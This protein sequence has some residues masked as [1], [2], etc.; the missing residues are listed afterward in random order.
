MGVGRD[1]ADERLRPGKCLGGIGGDPGQPRRAGLSRAVELD[2]Q[3]SP[4]RLDRLR[5]GRMLPE[6]HLPPRQR[7]IRRH[8]EGGVPAAEDCYPSRSHCSDPQISMHELSPSHRHDLR[9]PAPPPLSRKD[10]HVSPVC[11]VFFNK[12][13]TGRVQLPITVV[14]STRRQVSM[15]T[16]LRR[17]PTPA[18]SRG[19]SCRI[20]LRLGNTFA[21]IGA[22]TVFAPI[23]RSLARRSALPGSPPVKISVVSHESALDL[24]DSATLSP[25]PSTSRFPARERDHHTMLGRQSST[26]PDRDHSAG[27]IIVVPRLAAAHV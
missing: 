26:R 19:R 1:R 20:R 11:Q 13:V 18:A 27:W 16:S 2:R 9:K 24:L 22:S 23:R 8:A 4:D 3:R 12:W 5:E 14:F 7:Q 10:L 21:H 6:Q 17:R 25:R 15:V